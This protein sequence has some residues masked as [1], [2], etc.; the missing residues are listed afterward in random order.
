MNKNAATC[1]RSFRVVLVDETSCWRKGAFDGESTKVF[2]RY[3]YDPELHVYCCEMTPSY[4]MHFLGSELNRETTEEENERLL[5]GDSQSDGRD[6]VYMHVS[7]ISM[8]PYGEI[9]AET[10]GKAFESARE[11]LIDC[12]KNEGAAA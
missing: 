8:L 9:K 11:N 12:N 4:E 10:L 3:L 6:V 7:Y 5:E 1:E 2:G